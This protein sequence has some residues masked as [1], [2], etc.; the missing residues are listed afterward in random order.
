[1][2]EVLEKL[3]IL[4][5]RDRKLAD[6]RAEL[7]SL[8]PQRRMAEARESETVQLQE[9]ARLQLRHNET[10][11]KRLELE[12]EAKK[13]QIERY[14]LQQFQTKKNEEYRALAHEIDLAKRAIA[15]LE[16]EELELMMQADQL[17]AEAKA[18]TQRS[19][20]ARREVTQQRADLQARQTS[21]EQELTR[22][23]SDREE[24]AAD[25]DPEILPRYE[26]LRRTKG[27]R[28]VVGIAHGVC[29]GCHV[30]LP[31]QVILTCRSSQQIESCPNCGRILYFTRD[32]SLAAAE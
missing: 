24:L 19:E 32:M 15:Q 21:L 31:A 25:V 27:E 7:A 8:E 2:L 1:M 12:A 20:E 5:D 9:A 10:D 11:R 28:V 14:S 6:L 18:A 26:R 29:G 4:Q 16:D 30:R 23:T 3:L 22:L 13:Q 17:L